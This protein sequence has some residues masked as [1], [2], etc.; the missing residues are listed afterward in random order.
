M[1]FKKLNLVLSTALLAGAAS[2]TQTAQAFDISVS[3]FIR[4][5]MAYKLDGGENRFN[6]SGSYENGREHGLDGAFG[7][8]LGYDVLG[9]T[10]KE[11]KSQN[12]NWNVF[13]TKAELDFQ[14]TLTDKVTGFMKLR[15]YYQPDV[16]GDWK[17]FDNTDH[18]FD[19]D[20][21]Q[22][23]DRDE[24]GVANHGSEATY[25]SISD[26]NYMVDI[27]SLYIDYVDGP[28]WLRIGQ[29]QI[30]WGEG[31]F[32]RT[33]DQP[34]GLDVRRHFFL[35]YGSEEYADERLGAPAIR[36]SYNIN[37][38]WEIEVYAQMFQPSVLMGT[39]TSYNLIAQP[40][41][42]PNYEEG[43]DRVDDQIN[44]GARLRGQIG[45]LG[46]QL[47][48]IAQHS[49]TPVWDLKAGGQKIFTDEQ[50]A[51]PAA[52]GGLAGLCGF[53]QQPFVFVDGGDGTTSSHEWFY[54][55]AISGIDGVDVVNGL[56]ED[57]PWIE[58][59]AAGLGMDTSEDVITTIEGGGPNDFF[60]LIPGGVNGNDFVE[61]FP[62]FA[63]LTGF[64]STTG[65]IMAH[66][67][68]ENVYGAGLNY[69]FFSEPDTWL[70]QLIV[71][72]E[73]SYVPNKSFTNGLRHRWIEED[74]ILTTLV[75]EKY[76]RFSNEFPATYL[77]FQWHHRKE[78]D[79][80][81]RH[82]SGL[83]GSA[84]KRP[85]GLGGTQND[86]GWDGIVFGLSQPSPALKWRFDIAALYDTEGGFLF[87]P[88]VKWK[89]T[90]NFTVEAF[91][92]I[93]EGTGTDDVFDLY[94]QSDDL[95]FRI[96]YQF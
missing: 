81:G 52:L 49:N 34:N 82:L 60:G 31:L 73:A 67:E 55:S 26:N 51:N 74:E 70:D 58:A 79:L 93:I 45:N 76:H 92:N 48:A 11:D 4:Q 71:R 12:N 23:R 6:R 28:L 2:L 63:A 59:F 43:F 20:G 40:N 42:V 68:S 89:P 75:V 14:F 9:S 69:I 3:G 41:L 25:L 32:F 8:I 94:D 50:C 85:G 10:T 72:F 33:A 38:D 37:T 27:P 13:A 35:D 91:I 66:Y 1:K 87:Q 88:G 39:G 78:S 86:R 22:T 18:I 36:G 84:H 47:F 95:T 21:N 80:L 56:I 19:E 65:T 30:A 16:F 83:G 5:E 44:V 53:E 90:G 77:V 57:W 15:G 96:G 17:G 54:V 64:T 46:V 7:P 62:A 24:F 61:L 29:Q